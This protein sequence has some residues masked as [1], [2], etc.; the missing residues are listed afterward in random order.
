MLPCN[1]STVAY[2]PHQGVN[3]PTLFSWKGQ[4]IELSCQWLVSLPV[5]PSATV[6]LEVYPALM[7]VTTTLYC[8]PGLRF[9]KL[10]LLMLPATLLFLMTLLSRTSRTW[11][12]SWSPEA[13][14]HWACRMSVLSR[15]RTCS[16]LTGAGAVRTDGGRLWNN[17]P[18]NLS[19]STLY[20]KKGLRRTGPCSQGVRVAQVTAASFHGNSVVASW[21]EAFEGALSGPTTEDPLGVRSGEVLICEKHREAV[22]TSNRLSPLH[23]KRRLISMTEDKLLYRT[24]CWGNGR[25][26]FLVS[27]YWKFSN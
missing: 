6:C 22:P 15:L 10:M 13:S 12:E 20:N 24:R 3:N 26:N 4:L 1:H 25:F 18:S 16:L 23:T 9:W 14:S 2:L 27:E 11:Y 17:K 5:R 8:A 7:V 19:S 21:G